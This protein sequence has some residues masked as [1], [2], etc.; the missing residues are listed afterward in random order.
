METLILIIMS[1]LTGVFVTGVI[2]MWIL[3]YREWGKTRRDNEIANERTRSIIQSIQAAT[4]RELA[5]HRR[6]SEEHR[7]E[8]NRWF[9]ELATLNRMILGRVDNDGEQQS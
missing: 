8:N 2:T 1:T 3:H 6:F 7:L 9:Q 5:A 4:N